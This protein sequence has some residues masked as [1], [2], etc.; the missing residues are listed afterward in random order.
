MY[1]DILITVVLFSE[2]KSSVNFKVWFYV[3]FTEFSEH[4]TFKKD[5]NTYNCTQ[6]KG[7]PLVPN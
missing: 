4:C 5:T 3:L 6:T 2:H 7:S 1:M